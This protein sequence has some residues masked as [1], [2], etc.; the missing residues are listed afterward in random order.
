MKVWTT[1]MVA[2]AETP[3]WK[4]P[5]IR[6]ILSFP[7]P[8]SGAS[9]VD[10]FLSNAWGRHNN[11]WN[12]HS[13]KDNQCTIADA[14]SVEDCTM[15]L[16]RLFDSY[17]LVDSHILIRSLGT[18]PSRDFSDDLFESVVNNPHMATALRGKLTQDERLHV[19][20]SWNLRSTRTIRRCLRVA[21]DKWNWTLPH[22]FPRDYE[23]Y[24]TLP[25]QIPCRV[26]N[27]LYISNQC[28][29]PLPSIWECMFEEGV[30]P[31]VW[32]PEKLP[33]V[34]NVYL[35]AYRLL[36]RVLRRTYARQQGVRNKQMF[37]HKKCCVLLNYSESLL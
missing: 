27:A 34:L 7:Y 26:R 29:G 35:K 14:A 9:A 22:T 21:Q 11:T 23:S 6:T 1:K 3:L 25:V 30:L 20:V 31:L 24:L 36:R 13:K 8:L 2:R 16:D 32:N 12:K 18:L 28:T 19:V 33:E 15:F 10:L 4:H 17:G 37:L 5:V